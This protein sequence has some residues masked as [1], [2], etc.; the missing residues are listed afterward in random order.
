MV[1]DDAREVGR[2]PAFI[3]LDQVVGSTRL[4]ELR[5]NTWSWRL[6]VAELQL[7]LRFS[8]YPFHFIAF[9]ISVLQDPRQIDSKQP[10]KCFKWEEGT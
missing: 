5:G 3:T 7:E 8:F 2:S 1:L 10:H 6:C 4:Q 9:T